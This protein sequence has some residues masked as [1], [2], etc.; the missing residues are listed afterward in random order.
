MYFKRREKNGLFQKKL[1]L[2]IQP[3][4]RGVNVF[5]VVVGPTGDLHII[6]TQTRFGG[7][8]CESQRLVRDA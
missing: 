4:I 8:K 5:R 7:R 6:P 1:S 3:D 2:M